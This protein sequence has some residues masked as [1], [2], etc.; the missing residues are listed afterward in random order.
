MRRRRRRRRRRGGGGG[1]AG[2]R[3]EPVLFHA[4]FH[5]L[6]HEIFHALFHARRRRWRRRVRARWAPPALGAS[7]LAGALTDGALQNSLKKLNLDNN[8]IGDRGSAELA[9]A[10]AKGAL[11]KLQKLYLNDNRISDEGY[12]DTVG[13]LNRK[14]RMRDSWF[15]SIQAF[16]MDMMTARRAERNGLESRLVQRLRA[17]SNY[18]NV[19]RR[20]R[21]LSLPV[22]V[23]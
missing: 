18:C 6:F 4:L 21:T 17:C 1:G 12:A 3:A 8:H 11:T 23:Q 20:A 19:S 16:L 10:M 13:R 9:D 14:R 2:L 5:A 7:R 15:L 22:P